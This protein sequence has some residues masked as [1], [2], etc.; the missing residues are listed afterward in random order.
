MIIGA[1]KALRRMRKHQIDAAVDLEFFARSSAALC[2]L[3]GAERRVGLHAFANEASY[4]GDLMTHRL[5]Y[6]PH[7]HTSQTFSVMVESLKLS[8]DI[9]PA[10]QF[11]P[12]SF[13][14]PPPQFNPQQTEVDGVR[15]LLCEEMTR[16]ELPPMILL[17]PNCS[18]LLPLRRWPSENYVELARRLI[19]KYPEV[20]IFLTGTPQEANIVQ[21]LMAEI[22]SA[23]CLSLAGKTTLREL[24][25]LC[26]LAEVLVT[27][28]SGPAQFVVMTNADTVIMFGPETPKLFAPRSPRSHILWAGIA[29]SPC[30]NAYNDRY[31]TCRD[32]ICMQ[33]I[34]VDQVFALTCKIYEDRRGQN[35]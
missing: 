29:C 13:E 12:E 31:S 15:Q 28:D 18:D 9:L 33:Q 30:V 21:D 34:T 16:D 7:L 11:K 10:L 24:L 14:Q 20:H 4:R 5:S 3:S 1:I 6:N 25:V 19:D 32:N 35:H 8:P 22:G 26:T 27:N 17:N 23:R 2:Y